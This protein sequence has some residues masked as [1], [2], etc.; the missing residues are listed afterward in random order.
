MKCTLCDRPVLAR[1]LCARHYHERRR[2]NLEDQRLGL[3]TWR[4]RA[5][6]V[7]HPCQIRGCW[8]TPHVAGICIVHVER[9]RVLGSPEPPKSKRFAPDL[10]SRISEALRRNTDP[11]TLDDERFYE[12]CVACGA[13]VNL[14]GFCPEHYRAAWSFANGIPYPGTDK[15]A[16]EAP[17]EIGRRWELVQGRPPVRSIRL[18]VID[19]TVEV[20]RPA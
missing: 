3:R 2:R 15:A 6:R 1:G 18:Q 17:P 13:S 14:F 5:P 4:R 7:D 11:T 20:E 8:R 19:T 9:I 16:T 10:P 12:K